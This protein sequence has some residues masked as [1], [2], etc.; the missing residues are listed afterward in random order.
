M[1]FSLVAEGLFQ[2]GELEAW[3]RERHEQIERGVERGMKEGGDEIAPLLRRNL[4]QAL[5]I[6]RHVLPKSVRAKVYPGVGAGRLPVLYLGSAVPWL[7]IHEHGGTVQ[8][9]L[10]IPLLETRI[11][12]QKFKQVVA[13]IVRTGAGFF[14]QMGDGRVILFAEYQPEY[15]KPL[16][17]FRR[18][19]RGR[20]QAPVRRGED[21]P[22]AVL[23]PRVTLRKR[24]QFSEIVQSKLGVIA[25]AIERNIERRT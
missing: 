14:K 2:P 4:E 18:A 16:A 6:K 21:I 25:D 8:G 12:Y 19:E 5:K 1:K 9:P 10:L 20:R 23:V 15:G 7:G 13:T 24:L 3:G 22:I 11:G 17:R